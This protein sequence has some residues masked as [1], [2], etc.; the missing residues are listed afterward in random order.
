MRRVSWATILQAA[1]YVPGPGGVRAKGDQKL[2]FRIMCAAGLTAD[3]IAEQVIIVNLKAIG[4]EA[5]TDNK[6]GVALREARYKGGY[7]LLYARWITSASPNYSVFYGSKGPNNGMG[8]AN[9]ELDAV[10]NQVEHTMGDAERRVLF[11]EMQR[12]IATDIPVVPTTG[13]VN[14]IAVTKKLKNFVAN[15]TD[16]IDT[17]RWYLE[18]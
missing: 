8:Y 16:F 13:N 3:E 15:R 9:P 14:L 4:I 7:D 1:G 6:A 10:L 12:V 5:I 18:P 2:S 11:K 17:S